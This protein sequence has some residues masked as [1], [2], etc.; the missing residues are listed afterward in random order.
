VRIL[1]AGVVVTV[2]AVAIA[3]QSAPAMLETEAL[4]RVATRHGSTVLA[5]W[6]TDGATVVRVVDRDGRVTTENIPVT[7]ARLERLVQLTRPASPPAG[8]GATSA[9]SEA[10]ASS[11]PPPE[12][13]PEAL[14][15]VTMRGGNPLA[16]TGREA[17]AYRALY[18]LL[19]API[20][21]A[22]PGRDAL[23]TIV[24]DGPLSNLSFAPLSNENGRYL[25]E[26]FRLLYLPASSVGQREP[27][28]AA[29]GRDRFLLAA[30]PSSPARTGASGPPSIPATENEVHAI[31]RALGLRGA[32]EL[33]GRAAT[34]TAVRRAIGASRVVH[35]A[36]HVLWSSD[37]PSIA[38][39]F[40]A[41]ETG[42]RALDG[43]LTSAE[44][45]TLQLTADLVVLSASYV[46]AIPD[47]ARQALPHAF[48]AAGARAILTTLWDIGEEAWAAFIPRFYV[49]W[50]KS[51]DKSGALR[52]TQ[53]SVLGDLRAGRVKVNTSTGD[54]VLPPHPALWANAVLIGEP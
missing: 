1:L 3:A 34:E 37:R 20:R 46:G 2:A 50:Q 5:Y 26:D 24:P 42:S 25:L 6:V 52:A 28:K 47:D 19:I 53:L 44:I 18:E 17:G 21:L 29:A 45:S 31:V 32:V 9:A 10:E 33:E 15:F 4:L 48:L 16:A 36:T 11:L 13:V 12:R 14:R 40:F 41:P 54:M 23:I 43:R 8:S 51:G 27:V 38:A 7:R 39:L 30:N 49:E 22:L 35:L